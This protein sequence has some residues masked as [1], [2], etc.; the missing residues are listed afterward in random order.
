MNANSTDR[1]KRTLASKAPEPPAD[2]RSGLG[3]R[4]E[5]APAAPDW[6]GLLLGEAFERWKQR[7]HVG[8][9]GLASHLHVHEHLLAELAACALPVTNGDVHR[10][11]TTYGLDFERMTDLLWDAV[12]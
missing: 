7:K 1:G 11:C 4:S 12:S 6:H 3:S 2:G 9:A 8:D 10:L 5:P